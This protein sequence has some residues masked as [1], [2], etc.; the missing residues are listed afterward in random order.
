MIKAWLVQTAQ[1]MERTS[2]SQRPQPDRRTRPDPVAPRHRPPV[3][4]AST[5]RQAP[6]QART[7][8]ARHIPPPGLRLAGTLPGLGI[9]GFGGLLGWRAARH[10][11]APDRR[12]SLHDHG[13]FPVL[14][15]RSFAGCA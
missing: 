8:A 10:N 3:A 11:Q 2:A 12:L 14:R 15:V 9:M 7:P 6:P 5:N 4:A 13:G 1:R